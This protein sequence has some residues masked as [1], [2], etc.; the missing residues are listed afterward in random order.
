MSEVYFPFGAQAVARNG[1]LFFMFE[2]ANN[3]QGILEHG[4]SIIRAMARITHSRKIAG[5]IKFQ[6]RHLESFI[7][8]GFLQSHLPMSS[9]KHTG[10]FIETR[11]RYEDYEQ[12]VEEARKGNLIPFAT[13]FD[14]TSVEWCEA[15]KL[16]VI[17]IASCSANDW[18]L[19]HRIAQTN[20]PVI[21]STAGLSLRQIDE[22]VT[23]FRKRKIPLAIMHCIGI[24]PVPRQHLQMDQIRQLRQRYPDLVI[25]YSAHESAVDLDVVTIAVAS[26]AALLERHVGLPTNTVSLNAYSLAPADVEAW[27]DCALKAHLGMSA[28]QQRARLE[29]EIRSM[30]ELKRG[31]Y[32]KVDKKPGEFLEPDELMLAMPC[33]PG[34]FSAAELD[35]VIGLPVPHQGITAM[36]PIMKDGGGRVSPEILVSSILE[37]IRRMLTEAKI[38][39]P[40]GTSAEISHPNGLETFEQYGAVIIDIVNREYC[41]KLILQLRGQDHPLHKH[42]QK[43]ETFQVLM[44]EVEAEVDGKVSLLKEGD[45]LTIHRGAMHA[46]RTSTGMIMEEIS[47]THIKGDSVYQDDSIPSDPTTRKTPVVL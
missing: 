5:A 46:F 21:C 20:H 30:E 2:M 1:G 3:H 19:L 42:I 35:D 31:I 44:G 14:E 13:P 41:K 28:G 23:F 27:V 10:R 17:K 33:L 18:P 7:H 32:V 22:V 43:E 25:G 8:P 26:G 24:Y 37:R 47:T 9:N 11:L 6:F 39:L 15:L 38:V 40:E 4:L 12:M 34:Q 29:S 16:P 45:S 36:M